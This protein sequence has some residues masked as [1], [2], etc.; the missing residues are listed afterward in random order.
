MGRGIRSGRARAAGE[1]I[2]PIVVDYNSSLA[3]RAVPEWQAT[4]DALQALPEIGTEAPVGYGG[5]T[6]TAAAF[7]GGFVYEALAGAAGRITIR[8]ESLLLWDDEENNRQSGLTLVDACASKEKVLYAYPGRHNQVPRFE[9]DNSARFF[10]RISAGSARHRPDLT[11]VR[12]PASVRSPIPLP[13]LDRASEH[14]EP[15]HS[16]PRL[17]GTRTVLSAK[18]IGAPP[19]FRSFL[20]PAPGGPCDSLPRPVATEIPDPPRKPCGFRDAAKAE[21]SE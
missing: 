18:D 6:F 4:L 17:S 5:L 2:G 21:S 15:G 20:L 9:V 16:A 8:I 14:K 12:S 3:E 10:V 11:A 1:P 19:A 13:H 7:G